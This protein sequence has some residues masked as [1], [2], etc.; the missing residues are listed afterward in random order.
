MTILSKHLTNEIAGPSV[1]LDC[2]TSAGVLTE[3]MECRMPAGAKRQATSVLFGQ[4]GR[5]KP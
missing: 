4:M 5:R 2:V 3:R 1:R